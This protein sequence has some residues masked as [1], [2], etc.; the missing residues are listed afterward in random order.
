MK[1]TIL[2]SNKQKYGIIAFLI[3]FIGLAVQEV[4]ATST[5]SI[6]PSADTYQRHAG[7]TTAFG[8]QVYLLIQ[9]HSDGSWRREAYL[10]FDLPEEN[11]SSEDVTSAKLIL[12]PVSG[13]G[14]IAPTHTVRETALGWDE[15]TL[16][17]AN[18]PTILDNIIDERVYTPGEAAEFNVTNFI[19]DKLDAEVETVS[20]HIRPS[21]VAGALNFHSK[22]SET[23]GLWPVLEIQQI[24]SGMNSSKTTQNTVQ[25]L[26]DK[27]VVKNHDVA[28]VQIY[29]LAGQM[30]MSKQIQKSSNSIDLSLLKT[31]IY[32]VT[33]EGNQQQ[34]ETLKFII[35]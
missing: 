35:K 13:N 22:E 11:I 4:G 17:S 25:I 28:K 3:L 8:D 33:V 27:M 5:I 21:K 23:Q 29:D 24:A 9:F 15:L 14:E 10:K 1:Q 34:K 19:K 31:G 20:F 16:V 30:L 2:I 26:G 32:I 7:G 18:K 12:Y 6:N